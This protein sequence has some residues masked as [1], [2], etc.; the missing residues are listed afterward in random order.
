MLHRATR[1][2][3]LLLFTTAVPA[4]AQVRDLVFT[5]LP[6]CR[7][8]DTRHGSATPLAPGVARTFRFRGACGIPG[9]TSDGGRESNVAMAVALNVVAVGP[10]GPGHLAAWAANHPPPPASVINYSALSE[11]G[12]LNVA[13]GVIVPMCDQV[14]AD[15]CASG[16]ISFSANVSSTHLVVDV[17]GYFSSQALTSAKRYGAGAGIDN[18]PCLNS[19]RG[20]RAGLSHTIANL[21]GAAQVCPAG[22]WVC[23]HS[24][25]GAVSCDTSR[26][27]TACDYIDCRGDCH[28]LAAAEHRGWMRLPEPLGTPTASMASG[29]T[30]GEDGSNSSAPVCQYLPVWCCSPD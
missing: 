16:D 15:P 29:F 12:G 22:T 6:P 20:V 18:F 3:T 9:L 28:D 21:A 4:V 2:I 23:S 24:D 11:T 10:A 14:A 30:R 7:L 13:N 19:D 26:P 1:C 27:D 5:P 25:V 8:T 17:V